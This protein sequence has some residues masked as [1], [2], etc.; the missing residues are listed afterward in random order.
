MTPSI[1]SVAAARGLTWMPEGWRYFRHA[2]GEWMAIVLVFLIFTVGLSLVPFVGLL[3]AIL[4]PLLIGGI[5]HGCRAID[6]GERLEFRHLLE[7]FQVNTPN[8]LLLG[9]V[10]LALSFGAGMLVF[11]VVVGTVGM[12]AIAAAS[13]DMLAGPMVLGGIAMLGLLIIAVT[14]P[15][16]M[17]MWFAPA[18]VA[19]HDVPAL[20][21]VRLSFVACARNLPA[22]LLHSLLLVPLMLV[23]L[24]T[25]GLA[26]LVI[27]PVVWASIY[28]SYKEIFGEVQIEGMRE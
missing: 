25:L 11:L 2:P 17:A 16:A 22:L 19:F 4:V 10:N 26:L 1:R 28:I 8:L 18:L 24:L 6:R 7:G 15:I 14:V 3:N 9:L 5:M 27:L 21:A 20:D 13:A 12:T 23:T